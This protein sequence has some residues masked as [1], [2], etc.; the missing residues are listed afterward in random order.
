M[1]RLKP[2]PVTFRPSAAG[3]VLMAPIFGGVGYMAI[4]ML[5]TI[6]EQPLDLPYPFGFCVLC[7]GIVLALT[8]SAICHNH[9]IVVDEDGVGVP[10]KR[11][12]IRF[13]EIETIKFDI[14]TV[15]GRQGK[16]RVRAA[17]IIAKDGR[18]LRFGGLFTGDWKIKDI[19]HVNH[20]GF[21][22]ALIAAGARC[23]ALYPD[24]WLREGKRGDP[25]AIPHQPLEPS[26]HWLVRSLRGAWGLLAVAVKLGP[27]IGAIALKLFKSVKPVAALVTVGAYT[28]LF[29]WKFALAL[30]L[31]ILIHESGHVFAMWRCGLKVRGI[32]F[33]PFFGGIA[34]SEGLADKRL[35][36]T[37]IAINGPLWGTFLAYLCLIAF[38]ATGGRWPELAA[39][40][41]WGA[42]INLFNLLPI[43]PLDGGRI[44]SNLAFSWNNSLG[45][46]V[47]GCSL[48]LGA[49]LSYFSGL[50]LLVLMV[51]IG[52]Y[53]FTGQMENGVLQ[54]VWDRLGPGKP[55][56]HTECEH[57]SD[58]AAPVQK[59]RKTDAQ[60]N[61][62]RNI[63]EMTEKELRLVPLSGGESLAVTGCYI[64]LV[65]LLV[66]I[67][68]GIGDV[69]GSGT[70]IDLLR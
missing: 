33:I 22:M 15:I 25:Q 4:K 62:R 41:S 32:Y 6:T 18:K 3:L 54:D 39:L 47:V 58:M 10:G 43:L 48:F 30:M 55:F 38:L 67:L 37:Y 65:A 45:V 5:E 16:V 13:D 26:E 20:T 51:F 44:L 53:E 11:L 27:K 59:G 1:T 34:L 66:A 46:I 7:A 31:I 28:I 49:A 60:V 17:T 57:F 29:S 70:P 63:L 42:L 19:Y 8:H 64:A 56:T 24:S 61:A 68:F 23:E 21:L 35:D 36:N 14:L 2:K 40:A 69:P 12:K 52:A 50:E 9:T